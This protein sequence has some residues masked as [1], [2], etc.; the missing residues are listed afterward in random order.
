MFDLKH[1][2]DSEA[3]NP[4]Q[5]RCINKREKDRV[6]VILVGLLNGTFGPVLEIL[7]IAQKN[8]DKK[9]WLHQDQM[10][11][12][13]GRHV[14]AQ[15]VVDKPH[16]FFGLQELRPP[17]LVLTQQSAHEEVFHTDSKETKGLDH[18]FRKSELQKLQGGRIFLALMT[19]GLFQILCVY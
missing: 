5:Q 4:D 15:L 13:N 17:I 19:F 14:H 6:G 1:K 18:G 2:K 11:K 3:R 16:N 10:W 8:D 12:H 7:V 9:D